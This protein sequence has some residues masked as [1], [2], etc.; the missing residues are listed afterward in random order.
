MA[1]NDVLWAVL[2]VSVIFTLLMIVFMW[3]KKSNTIVIQSQDHQDFEEEEQA[4]FDETFKQDN[5]MQEMLRQ[6]A[7]LMM[8]EQQIMDYQLQ[9]SKQTPIEKNI[10]ST[11]CAT[12]SDD[13][14]LIQDCMK[15][16][17]S[18]KENKPHDINLSFDLFPKDQ[19]EEYIAHKEASRFYNS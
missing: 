11:Y 3:K 4:D 13:E 12:D 2:A 8:E 19:V 14:S 16:Q 15:F 18:L 7:I 1:D 10:R 6:E 9:K 17:N 5:H